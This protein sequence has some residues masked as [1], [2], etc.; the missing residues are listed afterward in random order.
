MGVRLH[1]SLLSSFALLATSLLP[2]SLSLATVTDTCVCI[3]AD[4]CTFLGLSGTHMEVSSAKENIHSVTK[5]PLKQRMNLFMLSFSKKWSLF[6]GLKKKKKK[7]KKERKERIWGYWTLQ[8]FTMV[9]SQLHSALGRTVRLECRW[10]L[11]S[12]GF[13][14]KEC[15][16]L[17]GENSL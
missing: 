10:I 2:N 6:N 15:G 13:V 11:K 16:E 5:V 3:Q 14:S 7:K 12:A 8:Q 4:L 9:F 17:V 1:L